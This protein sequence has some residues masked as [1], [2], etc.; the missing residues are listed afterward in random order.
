MISNYV[1]KGLIGNPVKKQYSRD[2]IAYLIFIAICKSVLSLDALSTFLKIQQDT[3]TVQRA[4]DYFV[5]EFE[6]LL[7]FT[8]DLTDTAE[9]FGVSRRTLDRW[10]LAGRIRRRYTVEG[11]PVFL[12]G[13]ILALW[14]TKYRLQ[15]F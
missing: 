3:Y 13:D 8:F 15:T 9:M 1:K 5:R 14:E 11:R 12:G 2:Q 7:L 4:Y 6:S 10:V